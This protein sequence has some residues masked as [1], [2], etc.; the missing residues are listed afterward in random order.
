MTQWDK[1][2]FCSVANAITTTNNNNQNTSKLPVLAIM[3]DSLSWE[4]YSSL[5]QLLGLAK[6][7]EEEFKMSGKKKRDIVKSAC[8]WTLIYRNSIHLEYVPAVLEAHKPNILILNRGAHYVADQQFMSELNNTIK[9]LQDWQRNCTDQ[10]C[11][12]F[13]RTTVP[14]HPQCKNY[15]IPSNDIQEMEALIA[16]RSN[17][18]PGKEFHWWDMKHQNQLMLDAFSKSGLTY[19][20][21]DAYDINILRPDQHRDCLHSCYPGK[22]DVYNQLMLHFLKRNILSPPS[23]L[24][25]PLSRAITN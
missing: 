7:T 23:N 6:P 25:A 4:H 14:G 11:W 15:T 24:L 9:V 5:I 20:V 16:N 12:L 22:M 10:T 8:N 1:Q 17:Y 21:I 18:A 13:V 19:Q 3:G 2:E